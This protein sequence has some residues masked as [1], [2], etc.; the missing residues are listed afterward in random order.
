MLEGGFVRVYRSIL[1]WEWYDDANTMRVFLH[2]ILTANY[3]SQKWHGITVER[4]QRV[5]SSQKLA[6]ELHMSRQETRTAIKHLILTGEITNRSTSEYSIITIKNYE[7][8]QQPTSELTSDQPTA[9]QRLTNDQ[10][11]WKKDKESNKAKKANKD[12]GQDILRGAEKISPPRQQRRVFIKIILNDKSL[13]PVYE[14]QIPHWKELYPAVNI[15]QELRNMAGWCEDNPQRRKTRNGVSRF[16]GHWLKKTQDRGGN[17][18]YHTITK[19]EDHT[20][21][22]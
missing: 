12:Q 6:K 8:Y 20:P 18:G 22:V 11:Q 10:P 4:G 5:Y 14:D 19:K 17:N 13:Y 1:K 16:I 2:L 7:L 15:E 21:W 9:N 3:E